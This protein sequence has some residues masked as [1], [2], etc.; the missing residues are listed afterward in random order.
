[1]ARTPLPDLTTL[2]EELSWGRSGWSWQAGQGASF[3]WWCRL[4]KPGKAEVWGYGVALES[5]FA[6]ALKTLRKQSR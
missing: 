6:R 4:F 5:A 2:I 3:A 1:M